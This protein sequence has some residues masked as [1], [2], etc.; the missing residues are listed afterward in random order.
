MIEVRAPKTENEWKAYYDL[1]F[2]V[3]REPWGQPLGSERDESEDAAFHFALFEN[4]STLE[5][6]GAGRLDRKDAS[7]YQVRYFCVA[8]DSQGKGYGK[9][10]MKEIENFAKK[11][12]AKKIIL[13]A[14]ENAVTFYKN[15]G[16]EIIE[17]SYLLFGEIQHY[18]MR[19]GL[20]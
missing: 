3:L 6:K 20:G 12:N 7:T 16:Y 5:L 18:L 8:S 15:L 13:H 19:K 1:R 4:N 9:I 17:E 14:R 10:L 11:K 2:V